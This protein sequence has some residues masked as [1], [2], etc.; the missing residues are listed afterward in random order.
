MILSVVLLMVFIILIPEYAWAWGPA[1]H[2]EIGRDILDSLRLLA[3]HIRELLSKFPH[4]FLYGNISADIVVAKNLT[5]ELK[6]CHNWKVGL[7]VLKKA[8]NPSQKAFAYGYLSHLAADTIAHN[9]YIP[10][11]LLISFSSRI[12]RHTYWE[13]RFDAMADK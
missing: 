2:L 7:K 10:E 11:R 13:L 1:T 9:Y 4:D 6:H 8:S 5:E 3:P 12:L